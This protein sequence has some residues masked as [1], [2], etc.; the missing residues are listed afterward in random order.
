M[1]NSRCFCQNCEQFYPRDEMTY[2][3]DCHGIVFRFVCWRCYD[4]LMAKGFDGEYYTELDECID[5]DY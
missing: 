3:R 5:E 4:K 1:E 2:T